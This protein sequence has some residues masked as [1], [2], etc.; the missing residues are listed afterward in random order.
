PVTWIVLDKPSH[1]VVVST[2][3]RGVYVMHDISTLEQADKRVADAAVYLYTPNTGVRQARAGHIDLFYDLKSAPKD[4]VKVEIMDEK[5]TVVPTMREA[6][7]TGR[8]LA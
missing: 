1:D 6:G 7:R 4:S 8:N 3:G 2:Y 5:G